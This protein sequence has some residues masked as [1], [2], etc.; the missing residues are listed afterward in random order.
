MGVINQDDELH[1]AMFSVTEEKAVEDLECIRNDR[2]SR[3]VEEYLDY[4]Y[5]NCIGEDTEM[6]TVNN[7]ETGDC[8]CTSTPV[9]CVSPPYR[10]AVNRCNDDV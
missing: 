6:C 10:R 1:I 2:A 9:R 7:L 4:A 5:N 8:T 3:S